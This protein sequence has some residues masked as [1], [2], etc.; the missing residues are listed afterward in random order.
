MR[1]ILNDQGK[2]TGGPSALDEAMALLECELSEAPRPATEIIAEL[3]RAGVKEKTRYRAKTNL[4]VSGAMA[5][6]QNIGGIGT[7]KRVI[8]PG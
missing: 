3:E 4:I 2:K 8:V 5:P 6:P 7:G 1:E